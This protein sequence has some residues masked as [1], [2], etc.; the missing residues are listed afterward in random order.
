MGAL[1][2]ARGTAGES[3]PSQEA[4]EWRKWINEQSE[5]IRSSPTSF[6][7]LNDAAYLKKGE[8]VYLADE[9]L[10]AKAVFRKVKPGKLLAELRYDGEVL[11]VRPAGEGEAFDLLKSI[12]AGAAPETRP[13]WKAPNGIVIAGSRLTDGD[14]R[15]RMHNPEH[16]LQKGFRELAFFPF[17]TEAR[18]RAKFVLAE[19]PRQVKM[20]TVRNRTQPAWLVGD[21]EFEYAGKP[22]RL[23]AYT[24]DDPGAAPDTGK[25]ELFVPF[26]DGTNGKETYAGG[27]YLDVPVPGSL[28]GL[29]ETDLDF[30]RAYHPLC[31]RSKFFNCVRV[32]S[33]PLKARV[34]AGERLDTRGSATSSRP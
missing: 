20:P 9:P 8:T 21:F 28:T 11:W 4:A 17:D 3:A 30:N 10:T 24:F 25:K 33:P 12:P 16:P 14:F 18:V 27:R 22:A 2:P 23:A 6:V 32:M 5:K 15:L 31:A 29:S 13:Q 26:R 1:S 19:S 7:N 34:Q